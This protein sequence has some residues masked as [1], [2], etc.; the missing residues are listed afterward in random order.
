[1]S[2]GAVVAASE[3][4]RRAGVRP[5]L[6]VQQAARLCPDAALVQV[7]WEEAREVSDRL[8]AVLRRFSPLVEPTAAGEAFLDYTGCEALFGPVRCFAAR[9]QREVRESTG[10]SVSLGLAANKLT[11]QVASRV[12][13]REG[14]VDVFPGYEREF[15]APLPIHWL[16]GIEG[17]LRERLELLAV[18]TIGDLQRLDPEVLEHVFGPQGRRLHDWARGIDPRR[19]QDGTLRRRIE[20][21]RSFARD[22]VDRSMLLRELF[23]LVERLGG[24]LRRE[25]L[26][27]RRLE[28][29][30][31]YADF[32]S[33]RRGCRLVPPSD[34]DGELFAAARELLHRLHIRRV[35][36][37]G[38]ALVACSPRPAVLQWDL[39]RED[40][41]QRLRRA[42]VAMDEIRARHPERSELIHFGCGALPARGA[43]AG[44]RSARSRDAAHIA[45]APGQVSGGD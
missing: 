4:A 5:G 38:L 10:L 37:R 21:R 11:S 3:E 30:I 2:R 29:I 13:G 16:P 17:V 32:V 35:R 22:L 45:R 26:Q 1:M 43:A 20:E 31:E 27:A 19:V 36:L 40:R 15:L 41:R 33:A 42:L 9:L 18:R 23:L 34:L 6:T 14:F 8:L 44:G 25:Q 24:R 12:A 28:L 7:D 39:F